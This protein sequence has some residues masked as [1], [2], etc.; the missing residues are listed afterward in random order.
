MVAAAGALAPAGA[1]GVNVSMARAWQSRAHA[2]L[3]VAKASA[4]AKAPA[5]TIAATATWP[6]FSDGN[7]GPDSKDDSLGPDS[8]GP[9][10]SDFSIHSDFSV[11]ILPPP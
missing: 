5:A 4:G 11:H 6:D 3:G 7:L 10:L 8:T 2:I 9:D 1:Y